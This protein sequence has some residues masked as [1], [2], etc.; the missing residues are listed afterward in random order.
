MR[1]RRVAQLGQPLLGHLGPDHLV[2]VE[3]HPLR[4]DPAGPGLADVV[5]Q[6]GHAQGQVGLVGVE[7]GR[8]LDHRD[9]VPQHVLVPVDRVLL[10]GQG[11][12]LG[13]E[14]GGQAGVDGQPQAPGRDPAQQQLLSSSRIRSRETIWRRLA[15]LGDG[16]QGL[17]GRDE[18]ELGGEAGRPQH[19]QRVVLERHLR[20]GRGAQALGR[21]VAKAAVGV[22]E[23]AVGQP[24]G[25]RVDG[26][27]APGQVLV[28]RAAEGDLGLAGVLAVGV[29]AEG[30]DLQP[31]VALADPDGAVAHPLQPHPV[32]PAAGP[33]DGQD[34]VGG[35]VGGQVDVGRGTVEQGVA[36]R[37]ADQVELDG[38]ARRSAGRGRGR[39]R[40]RGPRSAGRRGPRAGLGRARTCLAAYASGC[41][42]SSSGLRTNNQGNR[43]G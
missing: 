11:W 6:G 17:G 25:H 41:W 22:D 8:P 32:A 13:Q 37:P 31:E 15:A 14:L 21:Q 4:P 7:G 3:G 24:H 43:F 23:R 39:P 12:Q 18:L 28:D 10:Q 30:G 26:E 20:A 29:G 33:D 35:G 36:H 27:V 38:R 5:E 9:G 34:L 42:T 40:R 2:Q 1:S 19:P 16:G